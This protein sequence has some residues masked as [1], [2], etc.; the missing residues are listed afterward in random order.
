MLDSHL[1]QRLDSLNPSESGRGGVTGHLGE[2]VPAIASDGVGHRL[3]LG[4]ALGLL[5]I[6]EGFAVAEK[7]RR[8]DVGASPG[9]GDLRQGIQGSVE[10]FADNF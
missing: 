4:F 3:S 5:V 9:R 1:A 10:R 2:Q 7:P 6:G 8:R